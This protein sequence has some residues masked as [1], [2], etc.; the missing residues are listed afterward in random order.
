MMKQFIETMFGDTL[1]PD[2]RLCIFTTP[3]PPRAEFFDDAAQAAAYAREQAAARDVYFGL[4]LVKGQPAGRGKAEEM[5]AIGA[6]WADIDMAS[7]AH[8]GKALPASIED[9]WRLLAKL[10]T[11]SARRSMTP[12]R[13]GT[14]GRAAPGEVARRKGPA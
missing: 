5:A 11:S 1:G 12:T 2:R 7:P 3:P 4:G 13:R 9:V 14:T 10:R 8:N 6:L